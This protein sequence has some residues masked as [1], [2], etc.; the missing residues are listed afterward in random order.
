MSSAPEKKAF[1]DKFKAQLDE[2]SAEIDKLKAQAEQVG[3]SQR[4]KYYEYVDGLDEKRDK[5]KKQLS[6]LQDASG[7]ALDELKAGMK[8]A[9]QR[10]AIARKA[11]R[12]RFDDRP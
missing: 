2:L 3:A 8:D 11:A 12:A 6:E 9:W 4:M 10:L 1:R 7:D 5:I